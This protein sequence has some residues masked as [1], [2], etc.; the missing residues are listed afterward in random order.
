MFAVRDLVPHLLCQATVNLASAPMKGEFELA[1]RSP[2]HVVAL[3][4]DVLEQTLKVNYWNA[5]RNPRFSHLFQRSR[6]NFGVVWKHE[7]MGYTFSE[8]GKYPIT[9][10][11]SMARFGVPSRVVRP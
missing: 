8:C 6:P 11:R 4:D 7:M 1:V 3:A 10:V 2:S 9:K 5:F